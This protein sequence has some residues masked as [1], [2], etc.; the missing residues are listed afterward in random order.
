MVTSLKYRIPS[1]TYLKKG[2]KPPVEVITNHAIHKL[3]HVTLIPS[4]HPHRPSLPLHHPPV[5][6]LFLLLVR[7]SAWR[8][9]RERVSVWRVIIHMHVFVQARGCIIHSS[10]TKASRENISP[11]PFIDAVVIFDI[12]PHD[13]RQCVRFTTGPER[14]FYKNL[15]HQIR[16][17]K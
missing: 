14:V 3:D 17:R 10:L 8:L 16:S 13:T 15:G 9:V 1:G 6:K 12:N 5:P 2:Q 7:T 4:E 11:L